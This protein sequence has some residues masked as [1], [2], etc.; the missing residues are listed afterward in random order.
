M[1][2]FEWKEIW[3]TYRCILFAPEI[4]E[5]RLFPA[6]CFMQNKIDWTWGMNFIGGKKGFTIFLCADFCSGISS[7][8]SIFL[9]SVQN[10]WYEKLSININFIQ[11]NDPVQG[12]NSLSARF[13]IKGFLVFCV[14]LSRWNGLA[15][16]NESVGVW[17][18][19]R[20][21]HNTHSTTN[22]HQIEK[23]VL[24]IFNWFYLAIYLDC[25][26]LYLWF[27]GKRDII[28][29]S[30]IHLRIFSQIRNILYKNNKTNNL[31]M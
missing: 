29:Q 5:G 15:S 24:A 17:S 11:L 30:F 4:Y 18:L 23:C 3:K 16:V 8:I 1:L 22:E 2:I 21:T 31:Y 13:S 25:C 9:K 10:C 14:S 27:T 26:N 7:I 20:H 28:D 19:A 12:H 6:C